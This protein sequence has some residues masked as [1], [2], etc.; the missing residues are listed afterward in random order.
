MTGV[1]TC[2]LPISD[3]AKLAANR[4]ELSW[5]DHNLFAV[6]IKRIAN[7][8][9]ELFQY[10]QDARIPFEKEQGSVLGKMPRLVAA[11]E[12]RR[13]IQR[14]VGPYMGVERKKGETFRW[15]LAHLRDGRG[16]ATPRELVR[17]FKQAAG[18]EAA[19]DRVRSPKLLH[20]TALRQAL[21]DVSTDHV[22]QATHEWPWIYGIRQRVKK[23]LVPWNRR[24]LETL[25]QQQWELSWGETQEIRPPENNPSAFIDYLVELGVFR[26]RG[27]DRIDV[28]DIYLF[29][30]DLKRKGGV[31]RK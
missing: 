5:S 13:L 2:A 17:L 31:K 26:Q 23:Q 27:K 30:L 19:N 24:E 4:A 25:L 7:T 3:L 12:A 18:K 9:D 8:S 22:T 20:P 6:L 14:M 16:V 11:E 29:G 10:C 1:Q 21:E 28:P 15:V